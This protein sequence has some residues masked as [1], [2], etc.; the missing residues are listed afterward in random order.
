MSRA[1]TRANHFRLAMKLLPALLLCIPV[2]ATAAD[3]AVCS[4]PS[5]KGYYPYV[6]V[7]DK[8][9]SGWIDE[10]ITGGLTTLRK[11]GQ[12]DYDLLYVD[13]TQ[14]I[15][16]A[17][18]DGGRVVRLAKGESSASFFVAYAAGVVEVYTFLVD[19]SGKAEFTVVTSRAG[20]DVFMVKSSVMRGDCQ[21]V[22]LQLVD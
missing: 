14:T 16:S 17:R 8:K 21:Y 20:D 7:L 3:V 22:N 10:K 9:S 4:N 11:L 12:G 19:K 5:G 6:G 15:V 13:A 18:Q 2:S 1:E